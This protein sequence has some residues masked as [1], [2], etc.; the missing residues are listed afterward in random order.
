MELY[1][2]AP[3]WASLVRLN[4]NSSTSVSALL[5]LSSANDIR[6]P[7]GLTFHLVDIYLEELEKILPEA[8]LP[9]PLPTLVHPFFILFAR[10][11]N[12]SIRTHILSEFL[13]PL[14]KA[15]RPKSSQPPP[16]KRARVENEASYQSIIANARVTNSIEGCRVNVDAVR[17]GLLKKLL[18]ISEHQ[19]TRAPSRKLILSTCKE[20]EDASEEKEEY[21]TTS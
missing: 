8:A 19:E 11:P 1:V 14:L 12:K 13:D 2:D 20:Y 18:E 6:I 10:T 16:H 17:Q 21:V 3:G 4:D 7:A 15:L 9:A 5:G